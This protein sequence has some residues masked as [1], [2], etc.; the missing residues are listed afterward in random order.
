M[1]EKKTKEMT[2]KKKIFSGVFC[3]SMLVLLLSIVIVMGVL[4]SYYSREYDYKLRDEAQYISGGIQTSGISYLNDIGSDARQDSRITWIANDGTVIYDSSAD[5]ETMENHADREE[6]AAA[7]KKGHGECTRYSSTLA[8]KTHYYAIKLN[9][10]TVLRVSITQSTLLSLMIRSLP[11]LAA[12]IAVVVFISL[13][14][15]A[16]LSRRITEPVNSIDLDEPHK[17]EIYTELTPLLDKIADQNAQIKAQMDELVEQH[18]VR[19]EF[20]ANVT[21]ELK[22]PLTSILGFAEIMKSGLVKPED[23]QHFSEKI[24]DEAQRLLSLIADILRL[25]KLESDTDLPEKE[26]MDLMSQAE[27]VAERLEDHAKSCGVTL[28]VSGEH[29]AVRVI[30]Q[31]LDEVIFNI[32]E[33][34]IK[35][36]VPGGSA[37]IH[38][39]YEGKRPC[40]VISDTGKGIAPEDIPRIFERFY[41]ADKAHTAA[42]PGTGLGLSIV[43]HGVSVMGAELS[44]ESEPGRGTVMKI[45]F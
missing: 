32:T 13:M 19:K 37:D 25:S 23:M 35:Y 7:L 29:A 36:N 30:P 28:T 27:I 10:G 16:S 8:E 17:S 1:T 43:K 34:A 39:G 44:V 9:D 6:V 2:M 22:T 26:D 45:L 11:S 5:P 20:T 18:A 15:A 40:I 38:T 33:N 14:M 21:H 41:R 4:W 42:I 12:L 31:I 24:Y 3:T